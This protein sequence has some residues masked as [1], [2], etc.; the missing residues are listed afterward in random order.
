MTAK[1]A[2]RFPPWN[3]TCRESKEKRKIENELEYLDLEHVPEEYQHSRRNL[4]KRHS[5]SNLFHGSL[6]EINVIQHY[7][8]LTSSAKPQLSHPYQE[9]PKTL[10]IIRGEVDK[11]VQAGV[12]EPDK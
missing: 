8:Q 3:I 6:G 12:F 4:P 5:N 9:R 11:Q 7:I 10:L 1:L 2:L